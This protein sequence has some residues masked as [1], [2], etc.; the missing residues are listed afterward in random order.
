MLEASPC[1]KVVLLG[2]PDS[3][4]GAYVFRHGLALATE[5]EAPTRIV[6]AADAS[7]SEACTFVWRDDRFVP[8][9]APP[10]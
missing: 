7:A 3:L 2:A 6:R 9:G 10:G 4:D 1:P 8:A 5:G